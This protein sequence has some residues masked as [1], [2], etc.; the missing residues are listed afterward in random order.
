[1]IYIFVAKDALAVMVVTYWI[2][3]IASII[4]LFIILESPKWHL[5]N[6]RHDDALHILNQI[7]NFNGRDR[8]QFRL[9]LI[10]TQFK[11][12]RTFSILSI[13]DN[14]ELI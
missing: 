8:I 3:T 9:K 7:S 10:N 2:G 5:M 12:E 13:V 1:M 11:K 14:Q 4:L 6:G